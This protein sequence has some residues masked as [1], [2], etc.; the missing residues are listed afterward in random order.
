[1]KYKRFFITAFI[2]LLTIF[3]TSCFAFDSESLTAQSAILIDSNTGKVLFEKNMD[4]K[5]YPASTTKIMTAILTIENCDLEDIVKVNYNAISSIPAGYSTANL[6]TDEELTVKQLLEVLLVH[7]ANDA[8]N[9]LG[10]HVGGS[11]ESFVTMMNSKAQEL[12]CKNTNFTNTYGLHDDNH[13]TTARDLAIIAKYCMQNSS[14]RH[15]VSQP[16]CQISP[17]NK[18]EARTFVNT[19]NL[20]NPSSR[21]YYPS[22][23]GIKTG[24]TKE[25]GNCLI[26]ASTKDGFEAI[27]VVLNTGSVQGARCTD[28]IA[29]F[30]YAYENFGIKT[31]ANKGDVLAKTVISNGTRDTKDLDI[32][33]SKDISALCSLN[34][35]INDIIPTVDIDSKISAPIAEGSVVGTVTYNV[36]NT[37]YTADLLAGH[38]VEKSNFVFIVLII[39]LATMVFVIF[40]VIIVKFTKRNKRKKRNYRF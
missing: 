10:M 24:Y 23:I 16:N 32:V 30:D 21:Y 33:L 9:V 37:E 20:I 3:N 35:D 25:A 12:G 5:L 2:A 4:E 36:L 8:A 26:S 15:F 11:I 17:T 19:N 7:S 27:S 6:V 13:Y 40:I 22:A 38:D 34:D 28:S 1:M 18:H 39:A 29:L 14:F 31:I